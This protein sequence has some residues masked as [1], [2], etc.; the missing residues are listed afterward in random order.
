MYYSIVILTYLQK[1]HVMQCNFLFDRN[2]I[3]LVNGNWEDLIIDI[4]NSDSP[5]DTIN[6]I[7]LVTL[8][9]EIHVT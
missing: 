2:G 8:N 6:I 3:Y 1:N 4:A 9:A 7:C 5:K